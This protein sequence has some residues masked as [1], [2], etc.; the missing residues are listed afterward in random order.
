[1]H[2][3]NF[4]GGDVSPFVIDIGVLLSHANSAINPILYAFKIPKIKTAYR[5]LWYR[6]F[7]GREMQQTKDNNR[8]NSKATVSIAELK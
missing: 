1:M 2:T 7:S 6:L 4:Y 3:F 8:E 5:K